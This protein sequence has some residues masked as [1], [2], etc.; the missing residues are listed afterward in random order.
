[1]IKRLNCS[2]RL[3]FAIL[4]LFCAGTGSTW[5]GESTAPGSAP[6]IIAK[7]SD[8]QVRLMLLD[9]LKKDAQESAQEELYEPT[10]SGPSGPLAEILASLEDESSDSEDRLHELWAQIPHLAPDLHNMFVSL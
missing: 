5:A 10:L 6:A 2:T 7:M 9:E 1:M 8:E 3:L 4:L